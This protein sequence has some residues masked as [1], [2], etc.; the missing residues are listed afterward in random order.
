[1][2]EQ[3]ADP[4]ADPRA[5]IERITPEDCERLREATDVSWAAAEVAMAGRTPRFGY[6]PEGG[7]T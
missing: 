1:M 2:A 4:R 3:K 5:P 6:R 7:R